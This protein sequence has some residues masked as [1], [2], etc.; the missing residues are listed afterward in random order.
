MALQQSDNVMRSRQQQKKQQT[1]VP[2]TIMR[3]QAYTK[4]TT[5]R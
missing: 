4:Q 2:R 5:G 1:D 3:L